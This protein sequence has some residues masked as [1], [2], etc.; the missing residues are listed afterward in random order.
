MAVGS[1]VLA[2]RVFAPALTGPGET[3]A[4][5]AVGSLFKWIVV[6]AGLYL[7]IGYW[8]LP[9]MPTVMALVAAALVNLM[10]L[11]AKH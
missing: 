6:I 8:R 9:A 3:L 10:M 7:V 4:R 1:A 5:F 11:K 2:L